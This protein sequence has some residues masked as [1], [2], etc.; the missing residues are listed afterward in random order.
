MLCSI[1]S[2]L[3]LATTS[4]HFLSNLIQSNSEFGGEIIDIK[5]FEDWVS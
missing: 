2:G 3:S 4:P 1:T 5:R